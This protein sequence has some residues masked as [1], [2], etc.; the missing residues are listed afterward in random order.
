MDGCLA[1]STMVKAWL[2]SPSCV[3]ILSAVPME[4]CRNPVVTV[5]SKTFFWI[6]SGKS[7][8]GHAQGRKSQ[9]QFL[10]TS[11]RIH[12]VSEADGLGSDKFRGTTHRSTSE[13]L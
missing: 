10:K 3:M 11:D 5:T 8:D 7:A 12:C 1:W 13:R 2:C 4:L 6:R 9:S